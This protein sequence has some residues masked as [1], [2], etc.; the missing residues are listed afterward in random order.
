MSA[1]SRRTVVKGIGLGAAAVTGAS[2]ATSGTARAEQSGPIEHSVIFERLQH[3]YHTFRVPNVVRAPDGSLLCFANAKPNSPADWGHAEVVSK[4]STDGGRTWDDFQVVAADGTNKVAS[5]VLVDD[6]AGRI[7][8]MLLRAAGH[9]DGSDIADGTVSPED[10]PRPFVIHSDDSGRTWS[11]WRELTD[12][13]KPPPIRHYVIGPGHGFQLKHG[14]HRGRLIFPGN[15]SYLPADGDTPP[16]VGIHT[17]YSDDHGETW[18]IGGALGA[19]QSWEI[20]PNETTMVERA[21]GTLYFNSRDQDGTAPGNRVATTSSDGGTTFDGPFRIVDDLVTP[22]V[23]CSLTAAPARRD[24]Q[25]LIFAGPRHPT[26]REQLSIRSSLDGG[27]SW[28][29]GVLVYEGPAGYSDLIMDDRTLG[30]AFEQGPRLGDD[31][32]LSYHQ[33]IGFARVPLVVLDTPPPRPYR[34]PDV[35]GHDHHAI[36]GG[37]PDL[38]RG[39]FGRALELAGHYVEL[40]LTDA[41]KITDGPFTAALWFRSELDKVQRLVE[42]YNTGQFPKWQLQVVGTAVRAQLVTETVNVTI[43]AP[44]QYL[45][46][47]WH[48]VVLTRDDAG[49]ATV[50]VDGAA[51]GSRTGVTGSVSAGALAGCRFG[52]R[53]DGINNPVVGELDEILLYRRALGTDEIAGLFQANRIPTD[54]LV[55]LPL[56]LLRR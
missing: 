33:R 19:Y 10:A 14:P 41:T 25:R 23:H 22:I 36:V 7:H 6:E 24:D 5:S 18:Q 44:G 52:A 30:V 1:L 51:G 3:G 34:T 9:I 12:V 8:V 42:A 16:V 13:I 17:V 39:R 40:P 26:S 38:V 47:G 53:L 45:D 27:S 35:S 50:Y 48:H 11:E 29:E 46:G 4:R 55:H 31:T 56:E 15:H 2:Y 28:R 49:T 43:A 54:P 37:G 20:I 21:D 32:G